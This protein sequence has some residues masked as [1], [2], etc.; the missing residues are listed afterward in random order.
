M[1]FAKLIL[2]HDLI[3]KCGCVVLPLSN[4]SPPPSITRRQNG[5]EKESNEFY[6]GKSRFDAFDAINLTR[7]KQMKN[8]ANRMAKMHFSL[9]SYLW[10]I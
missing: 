8:S 1:R 10:Y 2:T 3:R 5:R 7:G 4:Q 6:L 9:L